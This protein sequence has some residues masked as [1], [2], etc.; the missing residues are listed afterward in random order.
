MKVNF[1]VHRPYHL[2]RSIDLLIKLKKEYGDNIESTVTVFDLV[3]D[4]KEQYSKTREFHSDFDLKGIFDHVII[5]SRKDEVSIFSILKF[6]R[7]YKKT[8]DRYSEIVKPYPA[9]YVFIFSDKEK[10]VEIIASLYK[11]K[12]A[13]ILM[14][15]EGHASYARKLDRKKYLLKKVIISIFGLN[16][17]SNTVYYG[18]SQ[19]IDRVLVNL[20]DYTTIRNDFSKLPLLDINSV[21]KYY[22]ILNELDSKKY[23]VYISNI[24]KFQFDVSWENEL[25]LITDLMQ[26]GEENGYKLII[27][28]HPV[29]EDEKYKEIKGGILLDKKY[30]SELLFNNE[31]IFISVKSSVLINARIANQKTVD[32]SK[33]F[34]INNQGSIFR[35]LE[36]PAI[37]EIGELFSVTAKNLPDSVTSESP[38]RN[39]IESFK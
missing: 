15:D 8:V 9:D 37:N 17:I 5:L 34:G 39:I 38:M 24:V 20:P 16:M 21:R 3:Y 1:V 29:E 2:I 7:Y 23:L 27:K 28:P 14:I 10:P 13:K 25:K 35:K 33:I 19:I 30:P 22:K 32:I 26:L 36:V 18:E 4:L 11:L 31:N 12:G 6:I